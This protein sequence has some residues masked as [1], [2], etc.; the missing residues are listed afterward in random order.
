MPIGDP[1]HAAMTT[2]CAWSHAVALAASSA[3]AVLS[4]FGLKLSYIVLAA[5][6][7]ARGF[8]NFPRRMSEGTAR[9]SARPV[10]LCAHP[11]GYAAPFGA[12]SGV[13]AVA[14]PRFLPGIP[15]PDSQPAPGRRLLVATGRSPDAA[16]VRDLL[17]TPAG[18]GPIHT[19][20]RN[21]FASLG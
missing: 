2:R 11:S 16:R 15:G 13:Y 4:A 7:C 20:R 12:P 3:F 21:R 1:F 6:I 14:G 18:T 17:V 10:F 19:T 5:H 8:A 9:R